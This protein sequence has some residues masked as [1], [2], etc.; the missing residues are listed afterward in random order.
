M[1]HVE[2][3]KEADAMYISI[4]KG[5]YDVSEELAENVIIDLD[6]SGRIMGIEV[7]DASKNLG[8]ELVTKIINTEKVT[9]TA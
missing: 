8:N 9:A 3:D 7:L 4:R 6:K 5:K 1:V 2:Y